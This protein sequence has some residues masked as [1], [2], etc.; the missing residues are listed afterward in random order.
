MV[1]SDSRVSNP[2]RITNAGEVRHN[3]VVVVGCS[4][5]IT[6]SWRRRPVNQGRYRR[7]STNIASKNLP[8]CSTIQANPGPT[9]S[10]PLWLSRYWYYHYFTHFTDVSCHLSHIGYPS[11]RHRSPSNAMSH[12]RQ[13]CCIV[14]VL[15]PLWKNI[16]ETEM[17]RLCMPL[18]KN[19][20]HM[21]A[22]TGSVF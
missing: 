4:C 21:V 17:E 15:R 12:P 20:Y 18:Q 14:G 8:H 22:M 16:G 10:S 19:W 6:G 9:D 2:S 1:S 11:W 5:N 7:G 13:T 3:R